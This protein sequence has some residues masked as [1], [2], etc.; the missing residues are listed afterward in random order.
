MSPLPPGFLSPDLEP[1]TSA[2]TILSPS[3]ALAAAAVAASSSSSSGSPSASSSSSTTTPLRPLLPANSPDPASRRAFPQPA[4]HKD[5]PRKSY[6]LAACEACRRRKSKCS[7]ERPICLVCSRRGSDCQYTTSVSETRGQALK[8]RYNQLNTADSP[9]RT[10]VELLTSTSD[11]Q[12]LAILRRLR[13][14]DR[15]EL[16][17]GQLSAGSA[18][19]QLSVKP[20]VRYRYV[21]PVM[22]EMPPGLV[23]DNPYLDSV[24]YEAALLFPSS[25]SSS[26]SP[27]TASPPLSPP[28]EA[29]NSPAQARHL[30]HV[31]HRREIQSLYVMPYHAAETIIPRLCSVCPSA[32]TSVCKDDVLMRNLLASYF[33]NDYNCVAA[34]HIDYFL[35]DMATGRTDYCSSLLVNAV[36]AAACVSPPATLPFHF[37]SLLTIMPCRVHILPLRTAPS[38]G[39]QIPCPISS[40]LRPSGYGR[41]RRVPPLSLSTSPAGQARDTSPHCKPVSASP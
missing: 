15:P 13:A 5:G 6:V 23:L 25:S 7:G 40:W 37:V 8:R 17:L 32:W 12:A 34:F 21:F 33:K 30:S 38:T 36:L 20:E 4:S 29:S 1:S 14:G 28:L 22:A 9:H 3:P 16:V 41:S 27:S 19:L 39:I 11:Q 26:S 24:L 31:H 18:L 10:L 35:E 2:A